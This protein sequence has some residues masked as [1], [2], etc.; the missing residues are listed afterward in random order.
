[1]MARDNVGWKRKGKEREVGME[2]KK[3]SREQN[4]ENSAYGEGLL[5]YCLNFPRLSFD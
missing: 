4:L 3:A 1:M 2:K 5:E